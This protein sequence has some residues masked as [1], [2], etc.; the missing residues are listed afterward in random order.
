MTQPH[1]R[2]VHVTS[3]PLLLD[4]VSW[5]GRGLEMPDEVIVLPD[6]DLALRR[7]FGEP[8]AEERA[9]LLA[10]LDIAMDGDE[11]H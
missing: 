2:H 3:N 1:R 7:F 11:D 6:E 5:R 10:R 9:A 4:E 8:T